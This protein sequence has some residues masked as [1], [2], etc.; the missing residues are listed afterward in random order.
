MSLSNIINIQERGGSGTS[1]SSGGGGRGGSGGG[2]R[3][4]SGGKRTPAPAPTP[5]PNQPKTDDSAEYNEIKKIFL[6]NS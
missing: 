1:G 4:G 2:G 5:T 6:Y 3:G